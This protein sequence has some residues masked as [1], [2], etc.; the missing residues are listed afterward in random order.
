MNA[1]KLG[2]EN[3]EHVHSITKMLL[4][5]LS[6]ADL[7]ARP[8]PGANHI[9]WQLG[10]L[11][12]SEHQMGGALPGAKMPALPEGFAARHSKETANSDAAT[13]F[14]TKDEYLKVWDE[15]RKAILAAIDRLTEADLDQPGPEKFRSFL[16]TIGHLVLMFASHEMMHTGQYTTVRRKL[17]KKHV[18]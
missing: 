7:L 10:H 16:P 14:C 11:I 18:F 6:D 3:I 15:Q 12:S 9:A 2:R 8:T 17:G 5:D 1:I 4:S 13:D